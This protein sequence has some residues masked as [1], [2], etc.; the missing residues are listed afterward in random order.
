[1]SHSLFVFLGNIAACSTLSAGLWKQV[2]QG[3][4]LAWMGVMVLFSTVRWLIGRGFPQ[5]PLSSTETRYWERRFILSV[6]VS[7]ALW[8][9]AGGLFF[10]SDH[11]DSNLYLAL[12]IVSMCA[13]AA[14]TLSY[15]RIAYPVFLLPAIVPITVN[16]IWDGVSTS[17]IMGFVLPFYFTLLYMLSREIYQTAHESFLARINSQYLAMFDYLTGVTN[18]RA[19]EETMEREWYRAMRERRMLALVIAD[20]DNF[21]LCNDTYGHQMGDRMLKKVATL[22]EK[23]IRRGA[24]LVARIGGE[25]FALILPDTD[26][27]G[28]VALAESIRQDMRVSASRE[29]DETPKLTMSFGVASLLPEASLDPGILFRRAD[30]AVYEAKRKGRDRVEFRSD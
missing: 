15:H 10:V 28:A 12:H 30:A 21:K 26:L 17:K 1:M 13:A 19:F 8:G 5:G 7:G 6:A 29:S 23:R 16:M 4:L 9:V 22:L 27:S 11:R 25:E 24:D 18:R 14:A 3:L 2:P 20:I